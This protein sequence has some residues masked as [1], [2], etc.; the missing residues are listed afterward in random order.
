M[1][2]SVVLF[3]EEHILGKTGAILAGLNGGI[4]GAW[5]GYHHSK[6]EEEAKREMKLRKGQKVTPEDRH[7]GENTLHAIAGGLPFLGAIPNYIAADKHY[8][9]KDELDKLSAKKK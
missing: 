3:Y 1:S 9:L 8:K 4:P 7:P 5:V 2:K 6:A